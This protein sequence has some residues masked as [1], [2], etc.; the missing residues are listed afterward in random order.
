MK[1]FIIFLSFILLLSSCA[2]DIKSNTY[3]ANSVGEASFSYQ[4]T[5]LS[6]RKVKVKD[7]NSGAGAVGGAV[8]GGMA[9]NQISSGG[10]GAGVG[11][12]LFG[13]IGHAVEN[14]LRTQ[15]AYEYVVKLTNGQ[16]LTVCQGLDSDFQIGQRVIVL[17]SHD[18]RSRVIAD[19]TPMQDVQAIIAAPNVNVTKKR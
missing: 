3:S 19:N 9:G 7:L 18:G 8:A 14:K 1:T 17:V 16:I 13:V 6:V 10:G 4:G 11:A 5:I 15:D 12:L 2:T